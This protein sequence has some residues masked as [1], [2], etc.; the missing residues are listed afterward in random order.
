MI[1]VNWIYIIYL[2]RFD[3]YLLIVAHESIEAPY[4]RY[5][6]D[7]RIVVQLVMGV[8]ERK[9]YIWEISE[10]EISIPREL[11]G[12]DL[13]SICMGFICSYSCDATI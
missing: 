1:L 5:V 8:L 2:T 6:H 4:Y 7:S 11:C 13:W 3:D 12:M 10:D 9:D